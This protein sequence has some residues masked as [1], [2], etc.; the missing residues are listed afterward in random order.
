MTDAP[1][2]IT[3]PARW[4]PNGWY[5]V[6]PVESV[7]WEVDQWTNGLWAHHDR[8]TPGDDSM[9]AEIGARFVMPDE[10]VNIPAHVAETAAQWWFSHQPPADPSD[11][12]LIHGMVGWTYLSTE[13]QD[14]HRAMFGNLLAYIV[15]QVSAW[16]G[17]PVRLPV[18]LEH[19]TEELAWILGRPNFSVARYAHLFRDVAGVKIA[20]KGEEEQAFILHHWLV[21]YMRHGPTGWRAVANAEI[22]KLVSEGTAKGV[23]KPKKP[24][25]T[26][27]TDR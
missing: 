25:P 15:P 16:A 3:P 21:L 14:W 4:R 18:P 11:D 24:A 9:Y 13:D 22:A 5:A 6:R 27:G 8:A 10:A 12:D 20:P 26:K 23:I 7:K 17:W 2:L 19:L 1:E